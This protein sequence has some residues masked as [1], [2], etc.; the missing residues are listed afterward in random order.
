MDHR[1]G[2]GDGREPQ[3]PRRHDIGADPTPATDEDELVVA[4]E[5]EP[6]HGCQGSTQLSAADGRRHVS[7][8]V[9][10]TALAPDAPLL[11]TFRDGTVRV[12]VDGIQP[13]G[14]A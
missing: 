9:D 3:L 4:R 13:P 12:R 11:L 14:E 2:Q 10:C 6:R 1:V 7:S 8:A 5:G